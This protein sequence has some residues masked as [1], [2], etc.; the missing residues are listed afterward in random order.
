M[1]YDYKNIIKFQTF[2]VGSVDLLCHWLLLT[3]VIGFFNLAHI[4]F[5]WNL[6]CEDIFLSLLNI[7]I[8]WNQWRSM[9]HLTKLYI[10]CHR[11]SET[12]LFLILISP[13]QIWLLLKKQS[14]IHPGYV[15][16]ETWKINSLYLY[17]NSLNLWL[18]E[19]LCLSQLEKTM[20][21]L[22]SRQ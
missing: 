19:L 15:S 16:Q 20:M 17:M 22:F 1:R 11:P 8:E 13:S 7:Y 18:H 9:T 10:C 3:T 5:S 2:G 4:C 6:V 12:L 14:D 21:C